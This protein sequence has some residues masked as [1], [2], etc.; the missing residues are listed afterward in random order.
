ME[1]SVIVKDFL[2]SISGL[3]CNI[4]KQWD[5]KSRFTDGLCSDCNKDVEEALMDAENFEKYT[6]AEMEMD[7]DARQESYCKRLGMDW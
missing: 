1:I 7:L 6:V 4:C 5:D 2:E 3:Q